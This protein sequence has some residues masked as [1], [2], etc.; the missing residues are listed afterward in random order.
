MFRW[1]F[2]Q[3]MAA[4]ILLSGCL[5]APT[6]PAMRD[7]VPAAPPSEAKSGSKEDAAATARQERTERV[8]YILRLS[9]ITQSMSE[10][11]KLFYRTINEPNAGSIEEAVVVVGVLREI[12]QDTARTKTWQEEDLYRNQDRSGG[13]ETYSPEPRPSLAGWLTKYRI[14]LGK[15]LQ[16]NLSLRNYRVYALVLQALPVTD[17]P[18]TFTIEIRKIVEGEARQWA[19]LLPAEPTEELTEGNQSQTQAEKEAPPP[20]ALYL[21]GIREGEAIL[22][23][24][25]ELA[26]KGQYLEAIE[27]INQIQETDP[28]YPTSREKIKTLSNKAVLLLRQQAAAAFERALPVGDA[29]ARAAWLEEASEL[30]RKA[31]QDYPDADHLDTVRDNLAVITRDLDDLDTESSDG[32]NEG[33]EDPD[34]QQNQ[35]APEPEAP[36]PSSPSPG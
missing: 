1:P 14:D 26:E 34:P 18:E 28:F 7:P 16:K 10:E 8:R 21:S 36:E 5:S 32:V 2:Y 30:L 31:L 17:N 13:E 20:P 25:G 15:S 24:A 9:D 33:V 11:D 12:L 19:A 29:T 3:A 23:E 27:L 22:S 6:N 35:Q 4:G